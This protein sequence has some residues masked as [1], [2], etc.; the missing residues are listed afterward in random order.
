M[1]SIR[2]TRGVRHQPS[3]ALES[4]RLL[5]V[6]N[7]CF[8]AV[9]AETAEQRNAAF[10]LRY[11]V[12][13]VENPFEDP[14]QNPHGMETDLYDAGAL[15]S[16][17][18]HRATREVI[19]TVRL[20]L[21]PQSPEEPA[22]PIRRVCQHDL[23]LH[24]NLIL[25]RG[26]TAEISRFAISKKFRRRADDNAT[27]VGAF[28]AG[29]D[30]LRRQIPNTSLGLMQAIVAMAARGGITHLCAVMEPTL[31]R[32]LSRLG[33]HFKPLGPKV[34]YHGFRQPCYS[35][36]D[37]LLARIWVHRADVWELITREG[38]LWPLNRELAAGLSSRENRSTH[39]AASNVQNN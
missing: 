28:S 39:P 8:E 26:K 31:L 17:L 29:T 21:P 30:D 36:L 14:E 1:S 5:D 38:S 15:H 19:G 22:L 2:A 35:D 23:I 33:I 13:C 10:R 18:F 32:M 20:I 16:L 25:P 7:S 4:S 11:D 24:E 3:K 37:E 27:L 34:E 9:V 12:Y 6:Y